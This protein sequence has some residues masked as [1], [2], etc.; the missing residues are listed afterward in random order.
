MVR[1]TVLA[2]LVL[3]VVIESTLVDSWLWGRRK[4]NCSYPKPTQGNSGL[5]LT[6]LISTNFHRFHFCLLIKVILTTYSCKLISH[7]F[8]LSSRIQ[9]LFLRRYEPPR[10]NQRQTQ[11]RQKQLETSPQLVAFPWHY[12]RMGYQ[13]HLLHET[14]SAKLRH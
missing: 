11:Y 7:F 2:A 10:C 5:I 13:L 6:D 9:W 4:T 12:L 1:S 14:H 8:M 3:M